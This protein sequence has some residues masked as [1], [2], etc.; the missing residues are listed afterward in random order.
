MSQAPSPDRVD[1]KRGPTALGPD[2]DSCLMSLEDAA[3]AVSNRMFFLD[4][5]MLIICSH[6]TLT[7]WRP[8]SAEELN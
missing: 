8:E 6:T 1:R 5:S 7:L 2:S 4:I 3:E